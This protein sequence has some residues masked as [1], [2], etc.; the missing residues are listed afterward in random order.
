MSEFA[1]AACA[2]I[3]AT[4][5]TLLGLPPRPAAAQAADYPSRKVTFVVG[6]APGGRIDTMARIVA[7][8]LGE[9]FGYPIV[10]ENRPGAASN[11]AAKVVASAPPDGYTLLFAG[12][13]L[14][15]NQ[16]FYKNLTYS[17]DQLQAVAVAAIDS[18]ALAINAGRP[19]RTLA[20][21][22][23]ASRGATFTFGYGGSSAHIV[24]EYVLK[25]LAK[26]PAIGVPF[27]SGAPTITA[28]LGN[29]V[30]IIAGPVA[31]VYPQAQQGALRALAVTGARR[32]QAF[33]EVPT[34]NET[35]FPG[36][37][38]NGWVG[39]LAPAK[40]P[41][42]ISAKLNAAVNAVVAEPAID[43]R[44]RETGYEPT[45]MPVSGAAAV[46][47]TSIEKWGRMLE[48]TGITAE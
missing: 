31:E 42:E 12:N 45:V 7:Q 28:L 34:L 48:A 1:K 6:F 25:V 11:I 17:I 21:F 15:I 20:E 33:P 23:D 29:H 13:S 41:P 2:S 10:V 27:Q 24:A 36:L 30:D 4:A 9:R 35:G 40:M 47:K 8:G 39:L 19:A 26:S 37:E 22:L 32:A 3:V 43:K 46:L 5:V 18:Q 38:I 44:L 16:T 14:A